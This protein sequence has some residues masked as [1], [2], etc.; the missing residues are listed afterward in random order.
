[1][2]YQNVKITFYLLK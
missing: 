1:M 2:T